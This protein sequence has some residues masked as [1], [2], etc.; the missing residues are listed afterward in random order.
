MSSRPD[1]TVL[2]IAFRVATALNTLVASYTV[3]TLIKYQRGRYMVA[4]SA[5]ALRGDE[6]AATSDHFIEYCIDLGSAK[7]TGQ[8]LS[9]TLAR[10]L[11]NRG[12]DV[13]STDTTIETDESVV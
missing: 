7:A 8:R 3:W 10:R 11:E 1:C 13:I 5:I 12:D 2:R 6:R 9:W 4:V